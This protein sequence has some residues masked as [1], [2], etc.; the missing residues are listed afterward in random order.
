[1]IDFERLSKEENIADIIAFLVR[2]EGGFGYPQMDRFL[3]V[4][5]SQ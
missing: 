4:I 2:K 5:T 1:M 3:V